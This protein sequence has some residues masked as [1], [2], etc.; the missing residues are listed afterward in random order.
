MICHIFLLTNLF[1]EERMGNEMKEKLFLDCMLSIE[2][3]IN[4]YNTASLRTYK[5]SQNS[6]VLAASDFS[7]YCPEAQSLFEG[8]LRCQ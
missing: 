5:L 2:N 6:L 3:T 7:S 4:F 8:R 1:E